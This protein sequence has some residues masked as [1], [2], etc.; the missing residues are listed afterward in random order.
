MLK[1]VMDIFISALMIILGS[2]FFF[3][4]AGLIKATDGGPIFFRQTR[5]GQGGRK[6]QMLKFRSMVIDA[7]NRKDALAK[8]NRHSGDITFKAVND[9]RVTL[10]GRLV[11]KT[12]VDE[13]PQLWNVLKGDMSLVGPRPPL[14]HE[15]AQY[16]TMERKRLEVKPGLTCLWQVAGRSDLP[17]SHQ[18]VLDIDY[19][20]NRSIVLDIEILMRT[21]PAVLSGRGAY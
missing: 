14:P 17:F 4:V 16:G 12:S 18:V 9:P 6:F 5:V 20:R 21:I 8:M 11:R 2:P 1:R 15:V 10:I 13:I 19:I 7:E 3:L